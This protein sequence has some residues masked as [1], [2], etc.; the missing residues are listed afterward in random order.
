[1]R[2][3]LSST[4]ADLA[5]HRRAVGDAVA[6]LK[7]PHVDDIQVVR[8]EDFSPGDRPVV[9]SVL[10]QIRSS[11]LFVLVLG[12]RY[13]YVPADSNESLI[14]LEYDAARRANRVILPFIVKDDY[15]VPPRQIETGDHAER[16]QRFK[17]RVSREQV[18][19][20][21]GSPDELA[22]EVALAITRWWTTPM[23]E[24]VKDILASPQLRKQVAALR[25]ER[26]HHL[27]V[28]EDLRARLAEVVPARPIW[29]ARNFE[30]DSTLCFCLLPFQD[31]FIRV[32][33]E[34]MLPAAQAAG[35]RAVHAGQIFDNREIVEDIWELICTARVVVADVTGRN[36]NVFYEL[37]V[38]HTLGK[39]VVVM[40]Q[41][42]DDVPFDIRHRRFIQCEPA[43]LTSLRMRLQQ[44]IQ[45]VL[46]RTLVDQ[47][48]NNAV[49]PTVPSES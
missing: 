30:L 21:F 24:A 7:I 49:E 25:S 34:G 3:F 37:G 27:E 10:E 17:E 26:I 43:K 29:R 46:T 31:E 22:K 12:W 36:P 5:E 42:A 45:R 9:E 13:G 4:F 44:T 2:V 11:D 40:T 16:L 47:S 23:G 6:A 20:S 28:I 19:R 35:L 33:E 1:M 14:E 48:P 38:C 39:E 8:A 32:F 15:P 41:A 18:V